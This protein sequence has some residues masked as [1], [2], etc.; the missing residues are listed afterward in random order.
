[1]TNPGKAPP[2]AFIPYSDG[3]LYPPELHEADEDPF[4]PDGNAVF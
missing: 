3:D 1:M 4:Q 2:L